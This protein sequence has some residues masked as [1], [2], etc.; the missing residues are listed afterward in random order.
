MP[1]Y[2]TNYYNP[3]SPDL[4]TQYLPTLHGRY[5]ADYDY[6][7]TLDADGDEADYYRMVKVVRLG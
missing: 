5:Q 2:Y 7:G 4:N 6:N 1:N 3:D